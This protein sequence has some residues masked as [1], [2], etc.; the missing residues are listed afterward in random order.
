MK[1]FNFLIFVL[2]LIVC[3]VSV[4][5]YWKEQTNATYIFHNGYS[6]YGYSLWTGD[7]I[8]FNDSN[9]SSGVSWSVYSG[10]CGGSSIYWIDCNP[11]TVKFNYTKLVSTG[12]KLLL[13]TKTSSQ[14]VNYSVP[15]DCINM[16]ETRFVFSGYR[17]G[18]NAGCE[19][20][21]Y[22]WNYTKNKTYALYG[23]GSESWYAIASGTS[24]AGGCYPYEESLYVNYTEPA[25]L[26]LDLTGYKANCSETHGLSVVLRMNNSPVVNPYDPGSSPGYY[27]F[28]CSAVGDEN[29]T[30]NYTL[31]NFTI[32][33]IVYNVTVALNGSDIN[34][35][36]TYP[37]PIDFTCEGNGSAISM[38]LNASPIVNGT[39]HDL[40]ANY[41][42]FSC[43]NTAD[44]KSL[45]LLIEKAD[46]VTS[47][48][49]NSSQSDVSMSWPAAS[50]A[51]A[52]SNYGTVGLFRNGTVKAN[53]EVASLNPGSYLYLAN[54][55]GNENYTSSSASWIL[56]VGKASSS[57]SLSIIPSSI[58]GGDLSN[59]SCSESHGLTTNLYMDGI[60]SANPRY[61]SF[62]VGTYTFLCNTSGNANYSASST[63]G[64]LTVGTTGCDGLFNGFLKVFMLVVVFFVM[65][66]AC[67]GEKFMHKNMWIFWMM[68]LILVAIFA[69]MVLDNMINPCNV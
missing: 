53:P 50:N 7:Y 68:A 11:A 18:N 48:Y 59:I 42:N 19:Y 15:N 23:A 8:N 17:W 28:N 63:S 10:S 49:L 46:S 57:L 41:Y 30:A 40:A 52:V 62:A 6:S 58:Q 64:T 37:Y 55:S 2:F 16:T 38:Y 43:N 56:T 33:P 13:R 60:L 31:G 47:L 69:I 45:F 65:I 22:C 67:F 9:Y 24:S 35:T 44:Q 36:G 27:S 32:F 20:A 3:S 14:S 39:T 61:Q 5:A 25:N 1:S 12:N 29:Y 54:T 26:S 21:W 4:S 66:A 34:R 51:S